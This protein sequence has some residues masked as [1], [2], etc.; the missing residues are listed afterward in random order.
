VAGE[1]VIA[2]LPSWFHFH[3]KFDMEICKFN[4]MLDDKLV[5]NIEKRKQH[6]FEEVGHHVTSIYFALFVLI[7]ILMKQFRQG[8]IRNVQQIIGKILMLMLT[9]KFKNDFRWQ[10]LSVSRW[11][12]LF[13]RNQFFM[14]R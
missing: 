3:L 9:L 12:I 4:N 11:S 6:N 2:K 14:S 8:I 1:R 5:E 7:S 10:D 13:L